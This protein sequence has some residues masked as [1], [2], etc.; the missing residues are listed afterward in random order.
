ML[1]G[2]CKIMDELGQLAT[3]LKHDG[4][5]VLGAAGQAR[6]NPI[7]AE[8]RSQQLAL[9][10]MLAQPDLPDDSGAALGLPSL[11]GHATPP[12]TVERPTDPCTGGGVFAK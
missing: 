11:H 3:S 5:T 8:L 2:V 4:I 6:L 7:V 12:G 9:G 10:K 1:A